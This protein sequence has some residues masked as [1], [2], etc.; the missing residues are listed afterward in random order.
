VEVEEYSDQWG[1][2]DDLSPTDDTTEVT[3]AATRERSPPSNGYVIKSSSVGHH[4]S[5]T[6]SRLGTSSTPVTP[7][8][9]PHPTA[10]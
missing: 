9:L 10:A 1:G 7:P 3:A 5:N 8:A 6:I 4:V 2:I